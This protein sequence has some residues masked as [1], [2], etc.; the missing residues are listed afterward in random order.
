MLSIITPQPPIPTLTGWLP[1]NVPTGA[2]VGHTIDVVVGPVPQSQGKLV[3]LVVVSTDGPF[4]YNAVFDPSGMAY[5]TIPADAT[6]QVGYLA[7]IV[8][9]DDARGEA[10][11]LLSLPPPLA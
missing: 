4:T 2:Q 6:R 5:F 7:L 8:A 9:A 11:I 1:L 3:G 10:S